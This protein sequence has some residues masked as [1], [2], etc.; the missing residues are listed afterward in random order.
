MTLDAEEQ[1]HIL[2]QAIEQNPYAIVITDAKGN[3]AYA[4]DTFTQLT[5]YSQD[6][7]IGRDLIMLSKEIPIEERERMRNVI[8]SG[9]EWRGEFCNKKRTVNFIGSG[10]LFLPLEIMKERLPI[11]C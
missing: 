11:S 4:N 2:S 9:R 10:Y 1:I 7:A 8:D 3:I 5:G 6:E